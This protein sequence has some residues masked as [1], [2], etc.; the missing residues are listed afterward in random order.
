MER[1]ILADFK[2][3]NDADMSA[4]RIAFAGRNIAN[5]TQA[6]HRIKGA[7]KM[8]GAMALASVCERIESAGRRNSWQDVAHEK[9]ALERE[10][11]QLNA[12]L[13]AH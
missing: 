4:L 12:W 3:A 5:V 7:C 10:F 13:S 9:A 8:V 6:S 2:A 1:E 11:E